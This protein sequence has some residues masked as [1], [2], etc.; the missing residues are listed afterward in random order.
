MIIGNK[1]KSYYIYVYIL[2]EFYGGFLNWGYL[3]S[4][5]MGDN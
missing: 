1:M 4:L 5:E 2:W 3:N